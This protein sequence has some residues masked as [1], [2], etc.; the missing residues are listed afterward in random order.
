M[1]TKHTIIALFLCLLASTSLFAQTKTDA[2]FFGHVVRKGSNEHLPFITVAIK[3]TTI[4]T[5][6][7]ATGHYFL[8]NLPIGNYTLVASGVG[9][10]PTEVQIQVEANK[11]KEIDFELEEDVLK[12]EET[13]ISANRNETSRKEAPVIVSTISPAIFENTNSVC[14][15]QGLNFQPGLR[16]ETNCQNCGFQQ[17]R[18]NGLD[19]P[20]SQILIDSRPIFS[21][22]AGVYGLEQ[23]PVNMI[24]RVEVIRGGGSALFGSNAIA[25]T[26]NI[27]TKEPTSN[28]VT[29]SNTTNLIA[30]K[31]FDV[32]TTFNSSI[33]SDNHKYGIM[34][35]GATRQRASLDYDGDG[36]SDITMIKAKNLG[37]KG[38]YRTSDYSKLT[39]E[40]HNIGE[41]RRGGNNVTL[42][43]HKADVAE[44]LNHNI[45]TGGIRYDLFSKNYNHKMALYA[46]AQHINRDSYY[47][48]QMDINAYGLTDDISTVSGIQYSYAANKVLFLPADITAGVEHSYNKLQDISLGYNRVIKQTVETYSAFAQN[49]WKSDKMSFLIGSRFDKHNLMKQPVIS[50]RANIRYTITKDIILRGAFSTGFR[51]PQAFDEDLHVSLAGSEA[52]LIE[53]A[54]DLKPEKSFSF[55]FSSDLYFKLGK[56]QNNLLLEGFYTDLQDVFILKPISNQNGQ[57]LLQRTNASGAVV[58]GFNIELKVVPTRNL[59]IQSGATFQRSDYIESEQWSEDVPAQKRMLRTPNRYGFLMVSYS[60]R[61]DFDLSLTGTYT[62]TMLVPHYAGYIPADREVQSPEFFDINFKVAHEISLNGQAKLQF[63]TGIQNI[64]NSYQNDFDKG[65]DR[66]AAYIYGPSLPRTVFVGVKFTI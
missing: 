66:D 31:A 35:F 50:P 1:K 26:I 23:I 12:L 11:S 46:S 10:K 8:K 36:F 49:E 20:Y 27:I 47:G 64:L 16:V 3:G 21:S 28:S 40:Y 19:G 43:P 25:G 2:N 30:G 42:P 7:D 34:F 9:Y 58:Q 29:L 18:I 37:F 6:T 4:G 13:V 45:N 24:E 39:L 62:G 53:L 57:A 63:N 55:S 44:Q 32:N 15:A 60:A 5:V 52:M 17:V 48:A 56:V 61:K 54:P 41:F 22:L 33:I 51:A 59:L 38:F 65:P 14:L